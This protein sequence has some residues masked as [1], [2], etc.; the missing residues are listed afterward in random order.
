MPRDAA[1]AWNRRT[2]AEL[3]WREAKET[4]DVHHLLG[5]VQRGTV[6]P[7]AGFVAVE[8]GFGLLQGPSIVTTMQDLE[9]TNRRNRRLLEQT[10]RGEKPKRPRMTGALA[11]KAVRALVADARASDG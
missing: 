11:Q 9:K 3:A 10:E 5:E 1:T 2:A 4:A 7:P 8:L 6:R